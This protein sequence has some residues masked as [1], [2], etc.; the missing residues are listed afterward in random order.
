[1]D[2]QKRLRVYRR[3]LAAVITALTVLSAFAGCGGP[4]V[5]K[6]SEGNTLETEEGAAP[7]TVK[8]AG[9]ENKYTIIKPEG[10]DVTVTGAVSILRAQIKK[11][12]GVELEIKTD[13]VEDA[14]YE[15]LIGG[16]NRQE[17]RDAASNLREKD[18]VILL[19]GK[20]I[21]IVGGNSASISR[22]VEY[23]ISNCIDAS[24]ELTGNVIREFKGSYALDSVTLNGVPLEDYVIVYPAAGGEVCVDAANYINDHIRE[25]YGYSLDIINTKTPMER[26]EIQIGNCR[27]GAS[28]GMK[29]SFGTFEFCTD[30][31]SVA[32]ISTLSFIKNAAEKFINTVIPAGAKGK[33]DT[34]IENNAQ[35]LKIEPFEFAEGADLRIMTFNVLVTDL[36]SRTE[37]IGNVIYKYYPDI[38]GL[39]EFGQA[40][41]TDLI[42]LISTVYDVSEANVGNSS[43]RSYTP[44]L[45]KKERLELV[46]SGSFYL[47]K[48][49]T[50]SGTKSMAWAVFRDKNTGKML[51]A[52]NA[53]WAIILDSYDTESVF[54]R[55]LSDSV[56]GGEWRKDNSRQALELFESLREKYGTDLSVFIM[57]DMNA[58]HNHD[59]VKMLETES[60]KCGQYAAKAD[61]TAGYDSFHDDPGI[62]AY[63]GNPIDHIFVTTDTADV[64]SHRICMD[65]QDVKC[66]DHFPVIIDVTLK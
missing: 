63:G 11:R 13:A 16:T 49:W 45:Y 14:G 44:I 2:T 54:G 36:A 37:V 56:E 17:S 15:I 22:A 32:I 5:K 48:R 62:P 20:K 50:G 66:S 47:E 10:A 58:T 53:H 31:D 38:I 8:Y 7:V 18:Y 52:I 40:G 64:L 51:A 21:V 1:M 59:S 30:D 24:G 26:P 9:G 12:T 39:Q 3:V 60:L 41:H 19:S 42:G 65:S 34:V 25:S 28:K 29:A 6:T 27:R 61:D 33:I 43:S 46:E 4:S 55:K 57:G 23:F 35:K